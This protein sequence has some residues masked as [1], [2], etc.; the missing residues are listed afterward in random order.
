[1][2]EIARRYEKLPGRTSHIVGV[3]RLWAHPEHL[4]ATTNY[5]GI[6]SYQRFFFRDIQALIIQ[7]TK[8]RLWYNLGFG[9]VGGLC[10][11]LAGGLWYGGTQ[12]PAGKAAFDVF[13][14]MCGIGAA[15]FLLG[16]IVNTLRGATCVLVAQMTTGPQTLP[17]TSRLRQARRI[18]ALLAPR[19]RDAQGGALVSQVP[20]A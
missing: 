6:E 1:M 11:L 5:F 7:R 20:P 15:V 2:S 10:A 13:A 4:L 14:V 16:V 19:I 17:G 8:V 18:L 9:I 12:F 3:S